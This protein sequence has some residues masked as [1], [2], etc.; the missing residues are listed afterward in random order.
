MKGAVFVGKGAVILVFFMMELVVLRLGFY[1][2][3]VMLDFD[4]SGVLDI[5]FFV[6]LGLVV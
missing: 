2:G 1:V 3:V 6:G 4:L 5:G